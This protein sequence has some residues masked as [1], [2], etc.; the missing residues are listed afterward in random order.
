VKYFDLKAGGEVVK[1]EFLLDV[2]PRLCKVLEDIIPISGELH[3]AK[4]TGDEVF[5]IVPIANPPV[6]EGVQVQE[7]TGGAI[8]YWPDRSLLSFL[9]DT[10]VQGLASLPLI[11]RV[12]GNLDGLRRIARNVRLQ[13]GIRVE[14]V[15]AA[16]SI[17]A[18]EGIEASSIG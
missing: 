9:C 3:F 12:I 14:I 10:P 8:A 5:M 4:I 7:M 11:G 6:E 2:C 17:S 16:D 18:G 1:C 13:Q 15:S